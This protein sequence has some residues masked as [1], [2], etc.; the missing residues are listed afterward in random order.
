MHTLPGYLNDFVWH[1]LI[2]SNTITPCLTPFDDNIVDWYQCQ[3]TDY[4]ANFQTHIYVSIISTQ[5]M[6]YYIYGS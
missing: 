5:Y 3:M 2:V 4:D 1:R 6:R